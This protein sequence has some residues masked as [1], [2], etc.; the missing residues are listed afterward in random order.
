MCRVLGFLLLGMIVIGVPAVRPWHEVLDH[1]T[2]DEDRHGVRSVRPLES[3]RCR[4][5]FGY[6][7]TKEQAEEIAIA[8]SPRS[9]RN[10][11][12]LLLAL[13]R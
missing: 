7:L 5:L 3:Q 2:T 11:R 12:R 13:L 4:P 8:I 10:S 1:H 9:N 6:N